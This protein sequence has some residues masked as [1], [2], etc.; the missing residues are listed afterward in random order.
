[1]QIN[2]Q[3]PP[4]QKQAYEPQ[5]ATNEFW[6]SRCPVTDKLVARFFYTSQVDKKKYGEMTP[7]QLYAHLYQVN[8]NFENG[9]VTPEFT[10]RVHTKKGW[11]SF[12]VANL[13]RRNHEDDAGR[14]QIVLEDPTALLWRFI[15]NLNFVWTACFFNDI[16]Y[17][18]VAKWWDTVP[19]ADREAITKKMFKVE[20][21]PG[22]T[23]SV[24]YVVFGQPGFSTTGAEWDVNRRGGGDSMWNNLGEFDL[25]KN[26]RGRV[27]SRPVRYIDNSRNTN[28][29]V[30]APKEDVDWAH[31]YSYS[32][33]NK[34]AMLRAPNGKVVRTS[35][36]FWD[37]N[38]DESWALKMLKDLGMP[39]DFYA[40]QPGQV[41]SKDSDTDLYL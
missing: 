28:V 23:W 7:Q 25:Y 27:T 13:C 12:N 35:V 31:G 21:V 18:D 9:I 37:E 14:C 41:V 1:M 40:I 26:Y 11:T 16:P 34:T 22:T 8:K 29:Y 17:I 32:S 4:I 5:V 6:R 33:L 38:A 2:P 15:S 36:G 30:G 20:K 24:C 10:M 3:A 39:R 19:M